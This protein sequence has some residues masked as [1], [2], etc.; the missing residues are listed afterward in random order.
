MARKTRRNRKN[1]DE[2]MMGGQCSARGMMG[3][4][5]SRSKKSR[6]MNKHVMRVYREMKAKDPNV[7]LGAA[8]KRAAA[9]RKKQ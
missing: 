3:G 7:K 6:R 9:E 2:S 5:K 1:E 8:M 4:K